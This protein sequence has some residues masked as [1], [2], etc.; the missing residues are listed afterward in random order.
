MKATVQS[1]DQVG[2]F[3]YWFNLLCQRIYNG[4]VLE[5]FQNEKVT[6]TKI[7][8]YAY[9]QDGFWVELPAITVD[10]R[11]GYQPNGS[12][13]FSA[14]G[15]DFYLFRGLNYPE[16]KEPKAEGTFR[17]CND[18]KYLA[19]QVAIAWRKLGGK[20][21]LERDQNALVTIGKGDVW[22]SLYG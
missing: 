11:N 17:V 21:K 22:V 6:R 3:I 19:Q 20:A 1:H 18:S 16:A 14:L 13:A 9:T 4:G 12:K 2:R 15:Y 10:Y 7:G 5:P 8:K